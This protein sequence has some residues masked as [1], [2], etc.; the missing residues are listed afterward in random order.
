MERRARAA[1]WGGGRLS[2]IG[3]YAG[4]L[5]LLLLVTGFQQAPPPEGDPEADAERRAG[6]PLAMI[7]GQDLSVD[8]FEHT[9]V[10]HLIRTGRN[11][12]PA[13]RRRHFAALVDDY[14]L[15]REAERRGLAQD[16]AFEAFL[17]RTYRKAVADRFFTDAFVRTLPPLTD[18]ELRLAFARSKQQVVLRHLLYRSRD[19]AEAAQA[20]LEAGRSFLE[21]AQAAYGLAAIDSSAG[22]LGPVRYFQVDD[23]IAEAAFRLEPGTL[24]EPIRSRYGYHI[25]RVDDTFVSPLLTEDDYQS[26]K[27][28]LANQLRLRKRRLGGDRFVQA[29]MA[30]RDV[31]VNAAAIEALQLLVEGAVEPADPVMAPLGVGE[32][33]Q[34]D[35]DELHR[36]V[37]PTTVLASYTW[38][39]ERAAFTVRDYLFWLPELP[40]REAQTRTAASVGR[41][42]RNEVFARA[43][44]AAGV[45]PEDV[46]DAVEVPAR[47]ELAAMLRREL[48]S[49][50]QE[51]SE[52][53]VRAAFLQFGHADRQHVTADLWVATYATREA[54]ME[55]QARAAE[56]A[57][58]SGATRFA[59]QDLRDLPAW[60]PHA[61]R[62]PIG[63]P[64]VVQG[65]GETW[66]VLHV[67]QRTARPV[68]F[69]EVRRALADQIRAYA[70]EYDLLR[71]LHD[72]ADVVLDTTRFERLM[73]PAA[74][75]EGPSASSTGERP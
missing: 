2:R 9:Y 25:L 73:D 44:Q 27:E 68:T 57:V 49:R 38:E 11:D 74:G 32:V 47:L 62:A 69:E 18:D 22:Y 14:L 66:A 42:L 58:P 10:H 64:V 23:A 45:E 28:G 59:D 46:A 48:R 36:A 34:L 3:R 41:A 16:S 52:A 75:H 70:A 12:T 65:A 5:V 7:E 6:E 33:P 60:G 71:T 35:I 8:W 1:P 30:E 54:A 40:L 29:F 56:G 4:A 53:A 15:A 31:R 50:P 43:G 37:E 39:G 55:A 51:P 20:R 72:D 13:E 26:R 63:S 67:E 17:T 19:E 24:S 21:E 61:R